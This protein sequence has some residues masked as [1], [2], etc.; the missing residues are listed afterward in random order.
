MSI[1]ALNHRQ[2]RSITI[3]LAALLFA[4]V[5]IGCDDDSSTEDPVDDAV[6][7]GDRDEDTTGE[8][9]EE[10]LRPLHHE[11]LENAMEAIEPPDAGTGV[12]IFEDGRQSDITDVDCD[13]DEDTQRGTVEGSGI[14]GDSQSFRVAL[15]RDGVATVENQLWLHLAITEPD[16]TEI[17][18]GRTEKN[19]PINVD[20]DGPDYSAF[21]VRH[22]GSWYGGAELT[23]INELAEEHYDDFGETWIAMTCE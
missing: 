22:A 20:D 17:A 7:E 11:A 8:Q 4:S 10:E 9:E 12:L 21:V 23:P 16:D 3:A 5:T 13:L 18:F 6:S 15:V 14:L 2:T 19:L 1:R